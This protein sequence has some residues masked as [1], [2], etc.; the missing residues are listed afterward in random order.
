[1]Q[2]SCLPSCVLLISASTSGSRLQ[3][4]FYCRGILFLFCKEVF[5][6]ILK[7]FLAVLGLCCCVGFFLVA[8][9]RACSLVAVHRLLTAVASLA[10]E[11]ACRACRL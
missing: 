11:Q 2:L 5:F 8:A 9:S 4:L 10:V 7:K 6:F 1:M 3:Q